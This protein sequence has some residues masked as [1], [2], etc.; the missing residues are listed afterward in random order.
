MLEKWKTIAEFPK[1]QISNLGRVKSTKRGT[2]YILN[3]YMD[4]YGYM[5]VR[6]FNI[7]HKCVNKKVH[8]LVAQAFLGNYSPILQVNHINEIKTD[9][10]VSNLEM[11][12]NK[13]NCNYG[14]RK[15]ALAKP[16]EQYSLTGKFIK[17]W[18]S[19]REIERQLGF[20]H[21]CIN[22]CCKGKIKSKGKYVSISQAY[23]YIW[24]YKN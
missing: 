11:C 19:S 12:T 5:Y 7:E 24:K 14:S 10:S 3:Q 13:Y 15:I 6:I 23:N 20:A 22:A 21:A 4:R 18:E 16:V 8:R 17:S 2:E 9:N 1:Y